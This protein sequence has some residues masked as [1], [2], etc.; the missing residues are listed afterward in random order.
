MAKK[1]AAPAVDKNEL[2]PYLEQRV[3]VFINEDE[4]G[5]NAPVYLQNGTDT[6]YIE[7]GKTVYVKRKFALQLEERA[8]TI[9]KMKVLLKRMEDDLNNA[10]KQTER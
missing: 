9:K 1:P 7:R 2:L 5:D 3:P 10:S 6:C 8:R 4:Y